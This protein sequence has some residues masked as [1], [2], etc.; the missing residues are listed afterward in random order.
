[1]GGQQ[2]SVVQQVVRPRGQG[3]PSVH[4]QGVGQGGPG[5]PAGGQGGQIIR[6]IQVSDNGRQR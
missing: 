3:Y 2:P 4:S 5:G 1:M 6:V